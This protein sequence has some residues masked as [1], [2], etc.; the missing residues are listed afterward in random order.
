M[1][2][3]VVEGEMNYL[4]HICGIFVG[5]NVKPLHIPAEE[6]IIKIVIFIL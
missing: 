2:H 1:L 3:G 5:F 6:E 4:I